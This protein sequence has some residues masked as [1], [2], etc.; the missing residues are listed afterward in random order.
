MKLSARF[1]SRLFPCFL[2]IFI[3]ESCRNDSPTNGT[4]FPLVPSVF[5]PVGVLKV[6]QG[7]AADAGG[8]VWVADTKN[9]QVRKFSPQGAQIDSVSS[10]VNNV[11]APRKIAIQNTA[12]RDLLILHNTMDIVRFV[13]QTRTLLQVAT[14]S[15]LNIDTNSVFDIAT[16]TRRPMRI[17]VRELGDIDS[18]PIGDVI[19]VSAHGTAQHSVVKI[20]NGNPSGLAASNVMV[21]GSGAVARFLATDASGSVFTSFSSER[22]PV[23][24]SQTY[25]L[26]ATNLSLSHFLTEPVV[27]G[28]A[29]GATTDAKGILYIVEPIQQELI[30]ISTAS[31]RTVERYVI[32]S[33][34]GISLLGL[35]AQDV[36]VAPDGTVYVV[37]NDS[38]NTTI[39]GPGAVIKFRKVT[40]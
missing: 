13:I 18:A 31:E 6:P 9:N 27:T 34:T 38:Q 30:L 24:L 1:T 16:S 14:L 7:I 39:D 40:Q 12:T 3:L 4:Q 15:S 29:R 25:V 11:V 5:I 37:V 19:Y 17:D 2:S 8:N 20:Q 28:A 32:P 35:A 26:S 33:V 36:A 22:G 21:T 23:L 10:G